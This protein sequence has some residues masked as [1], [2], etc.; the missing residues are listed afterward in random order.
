MLLLYIETIK[1]KNMKT[2]TATAE[3]LNDL[4]QI[5]NDRIEGYEKA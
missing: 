1:I 4:V 3:V 2:T 5:N